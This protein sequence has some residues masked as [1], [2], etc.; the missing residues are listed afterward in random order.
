MSRDGLAPDLLSTVSDRFGTP[1]TAISLTGGVMLLL[2]LFVPILEIAKL[3]SAFQ[4]L[5]FALI[6]VALV[7]FREGDAPDYDPEFTSR[8]TRGCRCS[9]S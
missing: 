4:I 8:C 6:N 9:A 3:A 2:N 5:V 7:G 1:V